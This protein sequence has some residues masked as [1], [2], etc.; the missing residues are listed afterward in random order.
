MQLSKPLLGCQSSLSCFPLM[1]W[2][3]CRYLSETN[4]LPDSMS[5]L[6]TTRFSA[7]LTAKCSELFAFAS[8]LPS[9]QLLSQ[10]HWLWPLPSTKG[11]PTEAPVSTQS[12]VPSQHLAQVPSPSQALPLTGPP[13]RASLLPPGLPLAT[14]LLFINGEGG[15]PVT[16][17]SDSF[18]SL[19]SLPVRPHPGS[20]LQYSVWP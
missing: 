15:G 13:P 14:P 7:P 6:G 10:A 11:D 1:G 4:N 17:S 19:S 18:C 9:C 20:C 2:Q 12:G 5:P 3:V 16:Q 8:P